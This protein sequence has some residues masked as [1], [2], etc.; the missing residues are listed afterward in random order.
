M[1]H[2]TVRA[3]S[4]QGDAIHP[5]W[6]RCTDCRHPARVNAAVVRAQGA[7]LLLAAVAFYG[8]VALNLPAIAAA[9]GW[10]Q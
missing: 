7:A 5:R 9:F 6:C 1:F 2:S 8:F 3:R 4:A 10:G